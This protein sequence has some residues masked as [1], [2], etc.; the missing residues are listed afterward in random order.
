MHTIQ[1]LLGHEQLRTTMQYAHVLKQ[2]GQDVQS[3]LDTLDND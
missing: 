3:P 2:S 1:K